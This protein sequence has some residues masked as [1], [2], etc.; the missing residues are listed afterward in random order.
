[1][2]TSFAAIAGV[3]ISI[4]GAFVWAIEQEAAGLITGI[5]ILV[6]GVVFGGWARLLKARPVAWRWFL[7]QLFLLVMQVFGPATILLVLLV[8]GGF[9][10]GD[11]GE[12]LG[13]I[14]GAAILVSWPVFI[15]WILIVVATG[16][17][18][19]AL[20]QDVLDHNFEG[21]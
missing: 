4:V 9:G 1:M 13:T 8:S 21:K 18:K 15:V 3:V 20:L 10:A 17:R 11:T 14:L 6:Y 7:P 19:E 12:F 5:G 16:K 2:G